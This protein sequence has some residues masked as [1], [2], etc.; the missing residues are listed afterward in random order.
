MVKIFVAQTHEKDRTAVA[1][2]LKAA[3]HDII[4]YGTD[5]VSRIWLTRQMMFT[6]QPFVVV[7]SQRDMLGC[8]YVSN[9]VQAAVLTFHVPTLTIV[10]TRAAAHQ[11]HMPGVAHYFAELMMNPLH[12]I[13]IVPK[14]LDDTRSNEHETILSHV[15][16]F[17]KNFPCFES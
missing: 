3:G 9:L 1:D 11:E 4:S 17:A 13:K 7:T 2:F 10:Y 8:D 15:N 12:Q 16:D 14:V 6:S 5:P